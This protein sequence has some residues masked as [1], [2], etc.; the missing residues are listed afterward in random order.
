MTEGRGA[1]RCIDA[2]GAEAHATGSFDAILD[3]TKASVF[4]A[5]DRAHVLRAAADHDQ[6][7]VR[8]RRILAALPS[9]T[10]TPETT[11]EREG[12]AMSCSSARVTR[13]ERCACRSS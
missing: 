6:F 4:L 9:E 2:V 10:L 11:S 12:R 1:D 3:K 5:T 13:R 8:D 7:V